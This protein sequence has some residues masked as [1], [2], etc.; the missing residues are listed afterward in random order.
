MCLRYFGSKTWIAAFV[1]CCLPQDTQVLVSPFLGSGRVER[2]I[3]LQRPEI[4]VYGTDEFRPLMNYHSVLRRNPQAL[5]RNL[6]FFLG[7]PIEK[8]LYKELIERI[9]RHDM[10]VALEA[11]CFF[12]VLRN[13]YH[14]K[15]GEYFQNQPITESLLEKIR[16]QGGLKNLRSRRKDAFAEMASWARRFEGLKVVAYL[17]PPYLNMSRSVYYGGARSKDNSM[18][19][20]RLAGS[21]LDAGV[22]F[23]MSLNDT[24][25]VR[26]TY[27]HCKIMTLPRTYLTTGKSKRSSELLI[28]G[29]VEFWLKQ[30][31]R[32]KCSKTLISKR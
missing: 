6:E 11:A 25:W 7:V 20:E 31:E 24:P 16:G 12:M 8:T 28:F 1:E 21:L 23:V 5:L 13:S 26:R 14:G 32:V 29:P 3:A 17:D 27:A 2:H 30:F 19:H 9:N 22:P 10:D 4:E 18:F 15:F